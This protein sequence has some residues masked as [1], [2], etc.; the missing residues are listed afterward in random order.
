MPTIIEHDIQHDGGSSSAIT[1]LVAIMAIVI[2][3]GIAAYVL[4]VYP[5]N[6]RIAGSSM[7]YPPV[8]MNFN[9]SVSSTL[10]AGQ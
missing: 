3:A 10:S 9:G 6:A 5:F 8:N 1:A 7:M 2:V 4:Q